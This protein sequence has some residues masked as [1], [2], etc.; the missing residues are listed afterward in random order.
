MLYCAAAKVMMVFREINIILFL[1]V[2][3]LAYGQRSYTVSGYVT[4][5]ESGERLIGATVYDTLTHQG[6][7]TNTAGFYTL[8][9]PQ[10]TSV[11]L[12]ARYVGYAASAPFVHLPFS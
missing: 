3:C 6:T 12:V 2:A 1:L 5:A 4:D 8:T 11:V 9:L 7:A 10:G